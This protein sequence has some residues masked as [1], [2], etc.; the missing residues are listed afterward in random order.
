M[1]SIFTYSNNVDFDSKLTQSNK[2]HFLNAINASAGIGVNCSQI[3]LNQDVVEIWFDDVL[4]ASQA[5]VLAA[6]V[7]SKYHDPY[8]FDAIV[9]KNG[10]GDYVS[11]AAA[12]ADGK[13]SVFVRDGTYVETSNIVLPDGGQLFGESQSNVRIVLAG[14]TSVMID[15]S[16]GTKNTTGT[17]SCSNNSQ[18]VTG[19]GTTFTASAPLNFILL[20]ADFYQI[21]S[22]ES[23][24]ALTLVDSYQGTALSNFPCL[25]QQMFTGMKMANLIIAQSSATGVFVR[26]VRHCGFRAVA[27]LYCTPNFELIDSGGLALCELISGFSNGVGFTANNAHTVLCDTLN[28]YNSTSD[29]IVANNASSSIVFQTCNVSNNNGNG[30]NLSDT[31]HDIN[32]VDNII[33]YNNAVGL[34]TASSTSRIIVTGCSVIDNGSHGVQMT[35]NFGVLSGNVLTRNS[36]DGVNGA[37]ASNV[38][39]NNQAIQNAGDGMSYASG[40]GGIVSSNRC[41]GNSGNGMNITADNNSISNNAICNNGATGLVYGGSSSTITSNNV[42]SNTLNGMRLTSTSSYAIVAQNQVLNNSANGLLFD[43]GSTNSV[44]NYNV[45]ANN[46]SGNVADNGTGNTFVGNVQV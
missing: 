5:S 19:S 29:G 14:G 23:D 15:G 11:V 42:Y 30:L 35:G 3:V 36:G 10:S 28:V 40:V 8:L 44:V 21:A 41:D 9:D 27:V 25:V 12:F 31:T 4:T 22:I 45:L 26:A 6:M 32:V 38:I 20:G 16:G 13:K 34:L 17:V 24:T 46:T 2:V 37:G 39:T 18:A 43:A 7:A 33:K 1:A